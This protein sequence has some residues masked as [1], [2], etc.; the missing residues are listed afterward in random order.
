MDGSDLSKSTSLY[1]VV[2]LV[3]STPSEKY[4]SLLLLAVESLGWL[5]TPRPSFLPET[6]AGLCRLQSG[7]VCLWA[8]LPSWAYNGTVHVP[9]GN[10]TYYTFTSFWHD[11]F[12]W[13]KYR[14]SSITDAVDGV[15]ANS[16]SPLSSTVVLSHPSA[17]H[18]EHPPPYPVTRTSA[19]FIM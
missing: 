17:R 10:L 12:H 6:I 13:E 14:N 15:I 3:I 4:Y 16:P 8:C 1:T 9:S 7:H 19:P 2:W 11:A 5:A 18:T